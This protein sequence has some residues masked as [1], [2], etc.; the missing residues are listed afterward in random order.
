MYRLA[1][2]NG[3]GRVRDADRMAV[4]YLRRA[5][6][7]WCRTWQLTCQN[8]I[9]Y[10]NELDFGRRHCA[11]AV[12]LFEDYMYSTLCGDVLERFFVSPCHRF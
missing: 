9:P 1:H 3:D 11:R 6:P 4:D 7:S 5:C 8:L 10:M 12:G 2:R